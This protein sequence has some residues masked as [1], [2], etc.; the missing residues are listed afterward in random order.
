[1]SEKFSKC[2]LETRDPFRRLAVEVEE[3]GGRLHDQVAEAA[4][5]LSAGH[6]FYLLAQ[7]LNSAGDRVRYDRPL[8]KEEQSLVQA[9]K[10][11]LHPNEGGGQ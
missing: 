4:N 8:T 2:T 10:A 1:V 9:A 5:R 7:V 3:E 6:P 11:F